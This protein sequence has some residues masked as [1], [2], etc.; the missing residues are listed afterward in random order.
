[1]AFPQV[2]Q[3]DLLLLLNR[4]GRSYLLLVEIFSSDLL[5]VPFG[6]CSRIRVEMGRPEGGVTGPLTYTSLPDSLVRMLLANGFGVAL[7]PQ[8]PEYWRNHELNGSGTPCAELVDHIS[9]A[10]SP[11]APPPDVVRQSADLDLEAWAWKAMDLAGDRLTSFRHADDPLF[12]ASSAGDVQAL[13]QV[14]AAWPPQPQCYVSCWRSRNGCD[15][16]AAINSSASA[17]VLPSQVR[18]LAANQLQR[19]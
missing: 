6:G 15:V 16:L 4:R 5:V 18:R 1:M 14:L 7:R 2:V 12:L 8:I 13:L 11:R 19:F 17:S 10:I 3:E 9:A